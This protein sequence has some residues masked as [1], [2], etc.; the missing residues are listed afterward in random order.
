[1]LKLF[2]KMSFAVK[3][4]ANEVTAGGG[5]ICIAS[6]GGSENRETLFF[7]N[8]M[9]SVSVY[10]PIDWFRVL[11]HRLGLLRSSL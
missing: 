11:D 3:V 7:I 10:D 2:V 9:S 1:M 8:G 6:G 5:W 4:G